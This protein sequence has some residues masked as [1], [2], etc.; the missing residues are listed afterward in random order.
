MTALLSEIPTIQELIAVEP[1]ASAM[2]KATKRFDELELAVIPKIQW[3]SLFYVDESLSE[4]HAIIL[5][6]VIEHINEERLPKI[7]DMLLY[8]MHLQH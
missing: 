4:K 1:S 2:K 5:C 6:E 8:S 7:M 3:G